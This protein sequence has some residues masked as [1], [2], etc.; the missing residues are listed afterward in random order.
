MNENLRKTN[1]SKRYPFIAEHRGGPLTKDNHQKL[2]MWAI[3]NEVC[4]SEALPADLLMTDLYYVNFDAFI[5]FLK[6]RSQRL[7]LS[8]L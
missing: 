4:C 1:Q 7:R 8:A 3:K 6:C 5:R 2:I